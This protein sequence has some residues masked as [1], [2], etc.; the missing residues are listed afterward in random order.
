MS[1]LFNPM[2]ILYKIKKYRWN[3]TKNF[4]FHF[5]CIFWV[6]FFATDM[7]IMFV[8]AS[9]RVSKCF[10]RI[11]NENWRVN[12]DAF[13]YTL[14]LYTIIGFHQYIVNYQ[15]LLSLLLFSYKHVIYQRCK[16]IASRRKCRQR[17]KWSEFIKLLSDK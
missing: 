10:H 15:S 9:W 5:T 7:W 3:E 14:V 6:V 12:M 17:V 1:L 2:T 11:F 13:E 16:E 4:M 8:I